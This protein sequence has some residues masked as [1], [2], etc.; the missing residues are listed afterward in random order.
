MDVGWKYSRVH[1]I[2]VVYLSRTSGAFQKQNCPAGEQAGVSE[3]HVEKSKHVR[4]MAPV[5]YVLSELQCCC[6]IIYR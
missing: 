2:C 4:K 5:L 3:K 1:S 6:K